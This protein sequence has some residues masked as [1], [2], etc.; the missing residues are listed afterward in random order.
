[1]PLKIGVLTMTR[2]RHDELLHQVDALSVGSVPPHLHSVVSMGDRDLTRG[3]LPLATDRWSTFVRPVQTDRRAL[4][5]AAARNAA[6]EQAIAEGAELLVFLDGDVMPGSRTLE[7]FADAVERA[8]QE[9]V[10]GLS[11]PTV[12]CGPVLRLPPAENPSVG[13]PLGQ[14]HTLGLRTPGTPPLDAGQ[15]R[16]EPRWDVFHATAFAMTAQDWTSVGGFHPAYTGPGLEDADF[17]ESVR[18]AGGSLVWVGGATSYLH[19]RDAVPA[20]EE[21]KHALSHAAIWHERWGSHPGHPWLLRLAGEGRLRLAA[22]GSFGP[23]R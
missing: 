18:R 15:L 12:W 8:G 14:L 5:L 20:Q 1:M 2:G 21:E 9:T 23:A 17:A 16:V 3:R 19:P 13:Y 7:R 4:P 6:A 10:E 11:A 22:D